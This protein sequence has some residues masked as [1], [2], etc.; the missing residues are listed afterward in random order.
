ML[1]RR[2]VKSSH[3]QGL[4]K[5]QNRAGYAR[6]LRKHL[7]RQ[8]RADYIWATEAKEVWGFSKIEPIN[9]KSPH[10]APRTD[11]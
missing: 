10:S 3:A 8:H 7:T 9:I 4:P 1:R 6:R 2:T 5:L 11:E